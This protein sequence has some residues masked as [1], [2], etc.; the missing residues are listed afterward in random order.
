MLEFLVRYEQICKFDVITS[1]LSLDEDSFTTF[2][3][4]YKTKS[5]FLTG[6][7]EIA[8]LKTLR[9]LAKTRQLSDV[10]DAELTR[11]AE[12]KLA[13][14][15]YEESGNSL[16]RISPLK[17]KI[18]IFWSIRIRECHRSKSGF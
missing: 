12:K 14:E 2:Q 10:F 6:K 16:I 9:R 11:T 18:W 15:E 5:A 3:N 1:F 17:P 13:N 4:C 8:N 7:Q